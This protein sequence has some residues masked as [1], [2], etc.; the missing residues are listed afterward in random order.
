VWLKVATIELVGTGM[1]AAILDRVSVGVEY[2]EDWDSTETVPST[3]TVPTTT[4]ASVP[5]TTGASVP[6]DPTVSDLPGDPTEGD[7][8]SSVSTERTEATTTPG[9]GG[10]G[11]AGLSSFSTKIG[12]IFGIFLLTVSR[13]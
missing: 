9:G 7:S 13:Y 2:Y 10:S 5:T 12:I 3:T 1:N 11:V 6:T 4:G 8:S